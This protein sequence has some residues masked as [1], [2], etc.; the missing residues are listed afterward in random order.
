M[1]F[2]SYESSD[3][4]LRDY[5]DGEQFR[6]YSLSSRDSYAVADLGFLKGGL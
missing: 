3:G 4:K 6:S 5:C 2:T 1:I